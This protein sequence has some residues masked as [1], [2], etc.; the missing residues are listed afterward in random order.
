MVHG[1]RRADELAEVA[2]TLADLGI[3]PAMSRAAATW[4]RTLAR[5]TAPA[6]LAAK[7]ALM[8]SIGRAAR[9]FNP[10]AAA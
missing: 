5:G 3:D 2:V 4:Q 9:R 7:L 10:V 1:V 6:G 8:A